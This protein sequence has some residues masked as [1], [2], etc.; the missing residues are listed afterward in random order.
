MRTLK[1]ILIYFGT[2]LSAGMGWSAAIALL[3]MQ[4]HTQPIVVIGTWA[5]CIEGSMIM[6]PA[7][8]IAS[9]AVEYVMRNDRPRGTEEI[10]MEVRKVKS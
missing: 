4:T 7:A 8:I 9:L 3:S 5:S 6:V 10:I 1:I 2:L